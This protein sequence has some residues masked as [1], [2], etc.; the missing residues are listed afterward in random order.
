MSA[1]DSSKHQLDSAENVL[2]K[3]TFDT[4]SLA[5]S[6]LQAPT[7]ES[8]LS[9]YSRPSA[10]HPLSNVTADLDYLSLDDAA[11]SS[12]AGSQSVLPNRG[13]SDELCYGT[14]TVY[15]GGLGFGGLWG[16]RE[17]WQRSKAIAAGRLARSLA[18]AS[19][20]AAAQKVS[21]AQAATR[22]VKA[23]TGPAAAA[24]TAAFE[25][26]PGGVS[27]R[28]RLN[29]ILNGITRR[30]SFTGNTCGIL[31]LMY[32]AFNCTLDRY[33][34]Q[35]DNW[36]SIM[37]GGLTGALFRCTAGPQKMLIAS[38]LMA[39]GAFGWSTVKPHLI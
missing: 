22:G 21:A 9:A 3:A 31:A 16:L 24:A 36:N 6:H 15:V 7:S 12:I 26:A 1:P 5:P 32:N 25:G 39:A 18:T 35:H 20:V 38:S 4:T 2:R 28:L 34:Q 19:G 33:R 17:G 11:L 30:G 23:P 27:W 13:W 37:A 10:L 14:G 8:I 29:A